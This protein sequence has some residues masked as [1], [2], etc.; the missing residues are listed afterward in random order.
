MGYEVCRVQRMGLIGGS[1]GHMRFVE[2]VETL[3]CTGHVEGE[4]RRYE[5][6][7]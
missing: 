7:A 5:T 6:V 4:C 1:G 2:G 3:S